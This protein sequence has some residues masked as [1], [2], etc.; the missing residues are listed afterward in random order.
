MRIKLLQTVLILL[1]PFISL[2]F[3]YCFR[4]L[5]V[6]VRD[7]NRGVSD[8]NLPPGIIR[9]S[10]DILPMGMMFYLTNGHVLLKNRMMDHLC[11]ELTGHV[12]IN[13]QR[14][15][16]ELLAEASG[17]ERQVRGTE[18][19]FL[20]I[21]KDRVIT[22]R[23]ES[24]SVSGRM[25]FQLTAYDTTELYEKET[26]LKERLAAL[27]EKGRLLADAADK[28][29]LLAKN[30]EW[31]SAKTRIHDMVGQVLLSA[32]YFLTESDAQITGRQVL[33]QIVD[34]MDDL[35]K[36]GEDVPRDNVQMT[37]VKKSLTD[38]ASAMGISLTLQGELP[39]HSARVMR[40][41]TSGARVCMTNAARHGMAHKMVI[42]FSSGERNGT[43]ILFA[44]DGNPP[45]EETAEGG[46]LHSLHTKLSDMGGRLYFVRNEAELPAACRFA[47]VMEIP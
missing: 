27:E 10:I 18:A 47:V 31:L 36:S 26:E 9:H 22:F 14:F 16:E 15:T 33:K 7:G 43:R 17:E 46:G 19:L 4:R 44:N 29:A 23:R 30:E 37:A 25:L 24:L 5:E 34:T 35:L 41:L 40:M 21:E 32:R 42:G 1:M 28:A 12:L 2:A 45:P 13:G 6:L 38:A 8:A 3:W 39:D 20:M 11:G